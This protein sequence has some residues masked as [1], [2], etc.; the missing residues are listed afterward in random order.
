MLFGFQLSLASW[1]AGK[2]SL[3]YK[4]TVH[5]QHA[6]EECAAAGVLWIVKA[7]S[8]HSNAT[9]QSSSIDSKEPYAQRQ[10]EISMPLMCRCR[11]ALQ[12]HLQHGGILRCVQLM[13]LKS[14]P[15]LVL[16][17]LNLAHIPA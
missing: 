3:V 5:A 7:A 11:A 14:L 2:S 4:C 17:P 12:V 6:A 13:R 15:R 10:S 1:A 9:P 8:Q 16:Q